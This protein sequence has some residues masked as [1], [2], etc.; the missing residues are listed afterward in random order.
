MSLCLILVVQI[1][2]RIIVTLFSGGIGVADCVG[3]KLVLFDWSV[4][5]FVYWLVLDFC[6]G[7]EF[8]FGV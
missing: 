6:V 7:I 2:E 4:I 5:I 3:I 8:E 1:V